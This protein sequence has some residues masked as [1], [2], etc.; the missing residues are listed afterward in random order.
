[1]SSF[2]Q[3]QTTA[4]ESGYTFV[5]DH[6]VRD[7]VISLRPKVLLGTHECCCLAGEAILNFCIERI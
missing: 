3:N 2:N 6:G 5:C 1:V 4:M 7:D